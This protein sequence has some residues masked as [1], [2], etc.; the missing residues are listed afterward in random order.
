MLLRKAAASIRICNINKSMNQEQGCV[1]ANRISC[2]LCFLPYALLSQRSDL[3]LLH[4]RHVTNSSVLG[5]R[6]LRILDRHINS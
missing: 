3:S 1:P 2:G 5:T 6:A 4:L